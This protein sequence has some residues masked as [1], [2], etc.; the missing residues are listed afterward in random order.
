MYTFQRD[1]FGVFSELLKIRVFSEL[2]FVVLTAISCRSSKRDYNRQYPTSY[3]SDGSGAH[4]NHHT[5]VRAATVEP[6]GGYCSLD[7]QQR[8]FDCHY[9]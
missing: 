6:T 3:S 1:Y 8:P 9:F 4:P 7:A 2:R 5:R